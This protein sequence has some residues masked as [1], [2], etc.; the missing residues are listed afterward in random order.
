[1]AAV[2]GHAVS[3]FSSSVNDSNA[4]EHIERGQLQNQPPVQPSITTI[5]QRIDTPQQRPIPLGQR[6]VQTMRHPITRCTAVALSSCVTESLLGHLVVASAIEKITANH[7]AGAD[8]SADI[9]TYVMTLLLGVGVATLPS[10]NVELMQKNYSTSL[11]RNTLNT[12]KLAP[13]LTL[14]GQLC[15][16]GIKSKTAGQITGEIVCAV[17][18]IGLAIFIGAKAKPLNVPL[19]IPSYQ[20]IISNASP[21]QI[22]VLDITQCAISLKPTIEIHEPVFLAGAPHI[23]ELAELTTW[24]NVNQSN[25]ITRLPVSSQ[26]LIKINSAQLLY[27]SALMSANRQTDAV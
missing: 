27:A 7:T 12:L 6:F 25:P 19:N 11:S 1:M 8:N 23:Y 24:L 3:G 4:L 9:A 15:A 14:F 20:N 26:D 16:A 21:S 5:L 22:A 13:I 17:I 10:V 2:T 18:T